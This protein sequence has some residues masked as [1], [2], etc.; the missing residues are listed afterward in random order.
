MQQKKLD[1][2]IPPDCAGARLDRCLSRLIPG[3]S[4]AY[5]QKLIKDGGYEDKVEFSGAF[6]LGH[7]QPG[8]SVSVDDATYSVTP[9][10]VEH[11]FET[12]VIAKL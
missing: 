4:R 7:C 3:S 1:F 9:E 2:H 5:L 12:E 10:T 8:V 6:C 11:F